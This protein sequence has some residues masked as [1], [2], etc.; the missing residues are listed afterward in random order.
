M[1]WPDGHGMT[2]CHHVMTSRTVGTQPPHVRRFQSVD[3]QLRHVTK[4]TPLRCHLAMAPSPLPNATHKFRILFRHQNNS[5]A[6]C[7]EQIL[8]LRTLLSVCHLASAMASGVPR[9]MIALALSMASIAMPSSLA[10]RTLDF[11]DAKPHRVREPRTR[12][13]GEAEAVVYP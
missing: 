12:V 8:Q 13:R 2:R 3:K 6:A 5:T 7:P 11:A 1:R 9:S 10:T 4:L